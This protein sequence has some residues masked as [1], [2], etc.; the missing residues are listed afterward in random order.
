MDDYEEEDVDV[1]PMQVESLVM[2]R[3][4]ATPDRRRLEARLQVGIFCDGKVCNVNLNGGSG[5]NIIL[6]EAVEKLKL[7]TEE[8]FNC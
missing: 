3:V 2:R 5:E 6:M 8:K 7:Y 1:L 4:L